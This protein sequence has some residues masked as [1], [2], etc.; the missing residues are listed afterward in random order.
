MATPADNV[1]PLSGNSFID[2]LIQGSAW[3][4]GGG[5]HAL[6]YSLSLNDSPNG[7]AW[8][9]G[10][11]AAVRLAFDNWSYVANLSFTETSDFTVFTQS[12]AEIAVTLTGDDIQQ[13]IPGAVGLGIFPSPSY[14]DLFVTL[15]DYDRASY[16]RPEGDV[17]LDNSFSGYNLLTPGQIGLYLILHEI[18]HA[19]GLKHP[20]DDGG[21]HRPTFAQLSIA[22]SDNTLYTVM[23]TNDSHPDFGS[24]AAYP[25]TPMPLD[26][27]AIQQIYGANM[28]W[29]TGDNVYQLGLTSPIQTIWDA[30][31]VDTID[32]S[33][34]QFV[35]ID[36]RP[37]QKWL[38]KSEQR[39]KWKLRV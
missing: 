38:R 3:Q 15:G 24:V 39:H 25:S 30:G 14:G 8:S 21:N 2:G 37:G 36:L 31:G 35:T 12:T 18:G 19:L 9:G 17:F 5:P 26:I 13:A 7:G 20:V 32:A 33:T 11:A 22:A 10:L 34:S 27:L 4:F 29:Q 28:G 16:P 23:S 1:V 6:S